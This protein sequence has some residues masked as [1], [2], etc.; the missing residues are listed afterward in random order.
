VDADAKVFLDSLLRMVSW[1]VHDKGLCGETK[2]ANKAETFVTMMGHV[3]H[4]N[5]E[6]NFSVL[7]DISTYTSNIIYWDEQH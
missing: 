7:F 2:I 6:N 5:R 3:K 4:D 1:I